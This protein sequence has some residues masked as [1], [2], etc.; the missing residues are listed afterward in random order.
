VFA[1]NTFNSIGQNTINPV[2]LQF[3]QL[4]VAS[5]WTLDVSG[6]L[7]FGGRAREVVSVV[8]EG[9]IENA[10]ASAVHAMPYVTTEVGP[11]GGDVALTWPEPVK[12]RVQVTARVDRP[13]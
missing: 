13:I 7:P 10:G 8:A 9:A 6:Y 11:G 5:T 2:T 1:A 4:S 3:D 12:G